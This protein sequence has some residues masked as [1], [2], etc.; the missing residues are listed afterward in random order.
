MIKQAKIQKLAGK[1]GVRDA[2]TEKDYI[3]S[4]ILTGISHVEKLRAALAFKGGTALKKF[5]FADHRF[6]EDID[7]TCIF[8]RKHERIYMKNDNCSYFVHFLCK[9]I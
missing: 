5:Y 1:I 3:L 6:S 7:F 9:E 4:W 8:I 2:Q